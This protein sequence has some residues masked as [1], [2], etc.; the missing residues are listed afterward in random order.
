MAYLINLPTFSDDRGSLSVVEKVLP[1]AIKRIFY[2]YDVKNSERGGHRHHKTVQ[3]A[4]CI[5]GECKIYSNDSVNE[6]IYH[7]NSPSKCLLL[8]TKDW[9][10]MYDFSEGAILLVLAS[11]EFDASD[12]IYSPY[13]D[14]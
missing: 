9:H 4:I 5:S 13:S 3:A 11:E 1:F 7:L 8:E 6:N 14:L 2:I 10:T 12:Y